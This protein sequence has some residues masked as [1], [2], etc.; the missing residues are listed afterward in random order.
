MLVDIQH[1]LTRMYLSLV[2][3]DAAEVAT[4]FRSWRG[5]TGPARAEKVD[6]EDRS[7]VVHRQL[8]YAG[9]RRPSRWRS[10]TVRR[11][12]TG[13]RAVPRRARPGAQLPPPTPRSRST[14]SPCGAIGVTPKPDPGPGHPAIRPSAAGRAPGRCWFVDD[15]QGRPTAIYNRSDLSRESSTGRASSAS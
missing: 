2:D 4:A 11:P 1:D 13:R 3:V 6:P 7:P 10:T 14:G 12:R 8:A 5:G 15:R 9:Q